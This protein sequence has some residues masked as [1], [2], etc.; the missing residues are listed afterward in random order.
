MTYHARRRFLSSHNVPLHL[1]F[2]ANLLALVHFLLF[3][4]P[5]VLPISTAYTR[6]W[7]CLSVAYFLGLVDKA[8]GVRSVRLVCA[9]MYIGVYACA[10]Q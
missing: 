9:C 4:L 2:V 8:G 3:V 7:L 6:V 10:A 1:W 5:V